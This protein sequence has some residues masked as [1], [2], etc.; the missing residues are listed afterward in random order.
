VRKKR[1]SPGRNDRRVSL[2]EGRSDTSP[3]APAVTTA[4]T[5]KRARVLRSPLVFAVYHKQTVSSGAVA[6]N[7]AG[8][9]DSYDPQEPGVPKRVQ[10]GGSF[11]CTD[12]YCTRYMVG[13]R[14]K[15]EVSSATNHVGFRCVK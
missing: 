15:G 14:G 7:P 13:S 9:A 3:R 12:Q 4:Q 6:V 5:G 8:P 1:T 11:L 2:S 10:K